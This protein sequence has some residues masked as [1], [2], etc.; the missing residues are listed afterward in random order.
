M[1]RVAP[2]LRQSPSRTPIDIRDCPPKTL[3]G[4]MVHA[5]ALA[6]Y[7]EAE[8]RAGGVAGSG[9]AGVILGRSLAEAVLRVAGLAS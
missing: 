7:S 2:K 9:H 8:A 5:H 6:A 4:V 1:T 3:T